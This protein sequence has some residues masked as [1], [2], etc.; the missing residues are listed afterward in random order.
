MVSSKRERR[1]RIAFAPRLPFVVVAVSATA[2]LPSCSETPPPPDAD[3]ACSESAALST[4]PFAGRELPP[5]TLALTFDDGPG[6]RTSELSHYL[7][8]NGIHAG[9][10]VNGKMLW[11]GT[12][13]LAQL[14]ADGHVIGNHTQNHRN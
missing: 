13:I 7:A 4:A 3:H 6:V 14:V 10:F 1:C 5:K 2:C 8:A 12:D 11:N 9:F